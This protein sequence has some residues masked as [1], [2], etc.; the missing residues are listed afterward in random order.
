MRV[1]P[2]HYYYYHRHHHS[3]TSATSCS[4]VRYGEPLYPL[5]NVECLIRKCNIIHKCQPHPPRTVRQAYRLSGSECLLS[6][7]RTDTAD[8]VQNVEYEKNHKITKATTHFHMYMYA[9]QLAKRTPPQ[10]LPCR[11]HHHNRHRLSYVLWRG[12]LL[13]VVRF[14]VPVV[15]CNPKNPELTHSLVVVFTSIKQ[16]PA[17]EA[18]AAPTLQ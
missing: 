14:V 3:M 7:L 17:T 16:R 9:H 4:V 11:H 13:S 8:M 1:I 12:I 15:E 2:C 6:L 5:N 18:A 10:P